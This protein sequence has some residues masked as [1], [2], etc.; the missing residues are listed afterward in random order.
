MFV[1]YDRNKTEGLSADDLIQSISEVYGA[2][3][4][5]V[6]TIATG[7]LSDY[8]AY[9][10]TEAVLARWQDEDYSVS[11][12]RSS[13]QGN[14]G[15]IITSREADRLAQKAMLEGARLDV[16]R[17]PQIERERVN[18]EAADERTRQ[19]KAKLVNKPAFRP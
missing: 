7:S 14:Y 17:A 19:A 10:S 11:L 6:A 12:I 4:R 15:L 16:L 3:T 2:P 13:R 18:Q 8:Y 9:S 5:P 1:D